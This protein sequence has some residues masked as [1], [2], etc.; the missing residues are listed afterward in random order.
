MALN[1]H[2]LNC[3]EDTPPEEPVLEEIESTTYPQDSNVQESEEESI[4]E[5]IPSIEEPITSI[6]NHASSEDLDQT[7]FD[8]LLDGC[9][10]VCLKDSWSQ[11]KPTPELE[12]ACEKLLKN[13][14]VTEKPYA[15]GG[16]VYLLQNPDGNVSATHDAEDDRANSLDGHAEGSSPHPDMN[17]TWFVN[18]DDDDDD[19]L[20]GGQSPTNNPPSPPQNP[21]MEGDSTA[22]CTSLDD[23]IRYKKVK[24]PSATHLFEDDRVDSLQAQVES[25]S[26]EASHSSSRAKGHKRKGSQKSS[27]GTRKKKVKLSDLEGE[28]IEETF[29]ALAKKLSK[30]VGRSLLESKDQVSELTLLLDSAKLDIS[31]RAGREKRLEEEQMA[32][33]ARLEEERARFSLLG[34]DGKRKI[35]E[36]EDALGQA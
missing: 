20:H 30:E 36:L 22:R 13:D 11:K 28:S 26:K 35:A 15:Y 4:D 18:L 34:E 1:D 29:L 2:I 14:P 9:D 23:L 3:V 27:K 7:F 10:F 25:K 33:R 19:V 21:G 5:E 8:S 16:W 32:K 12:G 24:S 6:D 17:F 31:N